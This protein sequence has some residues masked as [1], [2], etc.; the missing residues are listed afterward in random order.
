MTYRESQEILAKIKSANKIL[1]NCH[2]RPDVDSISSALS[3]CQA[4][5][6]LGKEVKIICPDEKL[7]ELDFLECYEHFAT[8]DFANFNFSDYDLFIILDSASQEVVTGS[9]EIK[10]PNIPTIV[11][12]HH[13]TNLS[14]GDINLIDEQRSAATELL[15]LLFVDWGIKITRP[16]ATSLLTGILGDTGAF[17]Y[18][19]TTPK[20]LQIAS[21]LMKKGAD[22][23]EI[24][25]KIF[26]SKQLNLLKFWGKVLDELEVDESGKFTWCA[27]AYADYQKLGFPQTARE[28]A[29]SS[30]IRMVEGTE[31]GIVMLEEEPGVLR[32]SLR[33]RSSD[34][35]VSEIALA[36]GGGGHSG[37]AGATVINGSFEES[38]EKV[39]DTAR[40]FI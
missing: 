17:E 16:L 29:S 32:V 24:L 8:I 35:D 7:P 37:A 4:L 30:F 3:M 13:M 5:H 10:L 25:L 39:V 38:V 9:K 31:F 11:I 23:D 14:F 19:N 21:K 6:Q 26:R 2:Q 12:D 36:L 27:I 22:K 40:K 20:T 33:S 18:H 15:Y 1:I 28:S 34:F